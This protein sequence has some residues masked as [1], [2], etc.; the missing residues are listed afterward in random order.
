MRTAAQLKLKL[1]D[2]DRNNYR[3]QFSNGI[4]LFT[5]GE[6]LNVSMGVL[7]DGRTGV[8]ITSVSNLGVEL[9]AKSKNEGNVLKFVNTLN[10]FLPPR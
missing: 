2:S 3:V 1:C 10:M 8:N 6:K 4:S 9:M 7:P 5:W